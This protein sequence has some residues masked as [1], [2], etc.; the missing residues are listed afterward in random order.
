VSI[1]GDV[2]GLFELG[3]FGNA[4][5]TGREFSLRYLQL[6]GAPRGSWTE[7]L[8]DIRDFSELGDYFEEK[9]HT[10]SAGMAA[11][12]YFSTATAIRHEIYL[13]DE[14]LSVGDEHFQTKSWSR[15]REHLV[16]GAS[17]LLVTH[18][19]SAVI[20]LCRRSKVLAAGRIADEGPSDAVVRN[21]LDLPKPRADRARLRVDEGCIYTGVAGQ[22]C[23]IAFEVEASESVATEVALSIEA[24]Q[25]GVGW[26][27]VILTDF[28]PVGTGVGRFHVEVRI[29]ELPLAPG[30]YSVNLFLS[31]AP[32]AQGER[33][34]LD[35]RG[36]TY[37]NGLTLRVT[38]EP[39]AGLTLL[40]LRWEAHP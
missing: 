20:K 10:Y 4:Q 38:G 23:R 29:P 31:A 22:A 1:A 40:A 17:G 35:T 9:I 39:A 16:H 36:W 34:S 25:L 19:W 30:D 28:Q 32:G 6:F 27:P 24:L 8:Q 26:E 13:I 5:L 2:A 15:M 11:R 33:E 14:I 3:G 7:L 21:Y 37:G 12:L 18:D